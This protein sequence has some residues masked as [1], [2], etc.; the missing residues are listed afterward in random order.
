MD[1][2]VF[3]Q[4][5]EQEEGFHQGLKKVARRSWSQI[6]RKGLEEDC[7][8]LQNCSRHCTHPGIYFKNEIRNNYFLVQ[9]I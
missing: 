3:A 7:Q 9:S 5:Q 6:N 1:T 8:V 4:V 2:I